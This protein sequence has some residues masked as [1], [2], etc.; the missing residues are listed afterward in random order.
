MLET[1][2]DS[3]RACSA[4]KNI[5]RPCRQWALFWGN[6]GLDDESPARYLFGL[7]PETQEEG[8]FDPWGNHVSFPLRVSHC[9]SGFLWPRSLIL[10]LFWRGWGLY[11]ELLTKGFWLVFIKKNCACSFKKSGSTEMYKECK[12]SPQLPSPW[13]II[14]IHV[15]W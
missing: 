1:L 8:W 6:H 9:Q 7:W 3:L 2:Y 13:Y 14:I 15:T 10:F 4:L 11:F 12:M 5:E